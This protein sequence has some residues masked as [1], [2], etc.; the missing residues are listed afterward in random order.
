MERSLHLARPS[1][2]FPEP[3][4]HNI[5]GLQ[6]ESPWTTVEIIELCRLFPSSGL[7]Q[8]IESGLFG[9][10][11][12]RDPKGEL[13]VRVYANE[14]GAENFLK[15]SDAFDPQ[16]AVPFFI[17]EVSRIDFA[18]VSSSCK[19]G[20]SVS[21]LNGTQTGTLGAW[22]KK[23]PSKDFIGVSNNHVL[24]EYGTF[25][26]GH[27]VIHPG[28]SA[29]GSTNNIL[30]NIAGVIALKVDDPS[31]P[32][33][34]VNNVDLAWIT[35]QDTSCVDEFIG[36]SGQRPTGEKNLVAEFNSQTGAPQPVSL[37]G[38]SSGTVTGHMVAVDVT[39]FTKHGPDDYFFEGQMELKMSSVAHGDSGSVVLTNPGDQI[40]GLFFALDP[41]RSGVGFATPWQLVKNEIGFEFD[42]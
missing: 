23:K 29:S 36:S 27:D 7:S 5:L 22:L 8:A 6:Q 16:I 32:N 41:G 24:A 2:L 30:G 35:P 13:C 20:S 39:L 3:G 42:Y 17:V 9:T 18:A 21:P 26:N 10:S 40:G 1:I 14:K 15:Q 33:D 4:I 34:T 38:C 31:R 19:G 28:I 25:T 11:V 37:S 12:G